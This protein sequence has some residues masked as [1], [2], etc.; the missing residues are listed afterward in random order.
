MNGNAVRVEG[1][2]VKFGEFTAV[3]HVSF[4][5]SRGDIFGFL[6]A[7]GAGKTTV[8]RVLCGLLQPTSGEAEVAGIS[9]YSRNADEIKARVGYMS[10][11][12][13]L[14]SDLSVEENLDFTAS[15]R[16]IKGDDYRRRR[17]ELFDFIAFDRPMKTMVQ[18]LPGGVKQQV[19][20][21]ASLLHDPEIVFLDEPTAGVTSVARARFWGLIKELAARGKTIF[22]TSH[23][24]DEVEQCDRIALMRTGELIA[25]S[26]PQTLKKKTFPGPLYQL[27]PKGKFAFSDM[28][29]V[30][31]GGLFES[32]EPHGLRY[33][34]IPMDRSSWNR[35]LENEG[36]NFT[37]QEITPTLEDVFIRL[38]EGRTR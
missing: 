9:I 20:L 15:L 31:Q 12:F 5:V 26:S 33:H 27:T 18:D 32:F 16:K 37:I 7:N 14:Y 28:E 8:I 34:A 10:Q 13:T 24:M 3:N 21:A 17:K 23:Y 6:G 22:V 4:Q 38:V 19:S 29:R 35:F 30:K 11:K 2:I 1:L 25:L 36:A